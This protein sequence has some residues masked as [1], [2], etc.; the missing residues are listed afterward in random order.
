VTNKYLLDKYGW[1][2][3]EYNQLGKLQKWLCAICG[4]KYRLNLDHEHLLKDKKQPGSAKRYKVRGLICWKCN[5]YLIS[6]HKDSRMLRKATEY[7]DCPP[8]RKII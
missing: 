3:V 1:T 8:A 4:K 5:K 2:L 6:R 7:L